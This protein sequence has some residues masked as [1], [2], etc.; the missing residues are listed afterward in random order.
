MAQRQGANLINNAGPRE[1]PP[2]VDGYVSRTK[3]APLAQNELLW[4]IVPS[5]SPEAPYQCEWAP[6]HGSTLPA[7]GAGCKVNMSTAGIPT[8]VWWEGSSNGVSGTVTIPKKTTEGHEGS[9]TVVDGIITA[10]T[11][12]T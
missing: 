5:Y 8:V 9:I 10:F 7:Q 3:P 12:P 1:H 4:V 6:I 2:V 11:N